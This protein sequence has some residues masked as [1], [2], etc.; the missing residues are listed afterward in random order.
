MGVPGGQ[1]HPS[2]QKLPPRTYR[3]AAGSALQGG[4]TLDT[5]S[6]SLEHERSYWLMSMKQADASALTAAPASAS[7]RTPVLPTHVPETQVAPVAV[8]S[9]HAVPKKPHVSSPEL[10]QAPAL[11]QQPLV[12]VAAQDPPL[13]LELLVLPAPSPLPLELL[14]RPVPPLPPLE[15]IVLPGPPLDDNPEPSTPAEAP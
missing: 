6:E 15:P 2:S 14:V 9:L 8:Q 3:T 4:V 7:Q 1:L 5:Q 12:Q 11:S 13:P 10:R